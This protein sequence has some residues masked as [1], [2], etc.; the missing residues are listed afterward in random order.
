M[1]LPAVKQAA[2]RNATLLPP[3]IVMMGMGVVLLVMSFVRPIPP[4]IHYHIADDRGERIEV[5][6]IP[7]DDGHFLIRGVEQKTF[8]KQIPASEFF[9]IPNLEPVVIPN[10]VAQLGIYPLVATCWLT[11]ILSYFL[12]F[13]EQRKARQIRRLLGLLDQD[14]DSK[15]EDA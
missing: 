5:T 1:H 8:K 10:R 15:K 4:R 2:R 11:P 13:R 12:V 14:D 6:A 3:L 7:Q 9:L